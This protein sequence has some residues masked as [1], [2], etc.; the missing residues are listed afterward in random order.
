MDLRLFVI[1]IAEKIG[2][3]MTAAL[4]SVL[5]PPLRNRLLGVGGQPQDRLVALLLGVLLSLW[6]AK[7]GDWWLGV[8]VTIHP[9]GVLLAVVLGGFRIGA[10]AGLLAGLF[11]HFR[12]EGHLGIAGILIS[13]TEGAL[14]GFMVERWPGLFSGWRSFFSAALVGLPRMLLVGVI[15]SLDSGVGAWGAALPPLLVQLGGVAAGTMIFVVTSRV[16]LAQEESAVALVKA[17]AA[18][19]QLALEALRRRLEPH[20]LF[21]ALNTLRATIRL[22]PHKARD[23]VSDLSALYRYLLHHPEQAPLESEV[24]HAVAYLAIERARLG[25]GRLKVK[26]SVDADVRHA[27]V[28][29]L[30]LQPLVE[31]A[32]KHGI[33]AHD[34]GGTVRVVAHRD[35]ATLHIEVQDHNSGEM[36]G[37]VEAGSGIALQTLRER[38]DKRYGDK[39]SLRLLPAAD[40]MRAVV[41]LPWSAPV[42]APNLSKGK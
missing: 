40:G 9:L 22:D 32:V 5:V 23:M 29:A 41:R 4:V 8:H 14:G 20:F 39:A 15:L 11:Y 34:Q 36:L 16:V 19:D 21:N 3:V 28:P 42:P 25:E 38:L 18:A 10:L 31:N 1:D 33:A 7:M 27:T 35:G 2:L 30:L 37:T 12:V 6:G 17:Q 13:V 26:T 24:E